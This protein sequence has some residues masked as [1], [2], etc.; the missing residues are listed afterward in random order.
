MENRLANEIHEFSEKGIPA[1]SR[2]REM[3]LNVHFDI[4]FASIIEVSSHFSY[5]APEVLQVLIGCPLCAKHGSPALHGKSRLD[6]VPKI[7]FMT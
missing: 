5:E 1:G 4:A 7:S 6:D 2:Y 3:K